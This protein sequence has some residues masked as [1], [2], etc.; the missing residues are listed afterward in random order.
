M[1]YHDI[2]HED[3]K[4]GVGMRVVLFVSGCKHKCRNCQNPQTWDIN[5]GVKFDKDAKKE[6]F[7]AL[8]KKH[9]D[10]ITFSG[11]DPFHP[12]NRKEIIKLAK[13]IKTKFKD[14][15]NIWLYTG[16]AWEKI[17]D[18]TGIENIDVIVDGE[19]V[20]SKRSPNT[21]WVGSSNQRV[22][23]VKNTLSAGKI[24]LHKEGK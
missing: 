12:T 10:G 11:G 1:N 7:D 5:G 8:S 21:P 3:M 24:V 22:I 16:Y 23:D 9:I 13:E 2:L 20:Y 18:I 15:K 6:L 4:N 17:K 14:T 19:F